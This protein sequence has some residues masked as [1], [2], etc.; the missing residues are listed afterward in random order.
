MPSIVLAEF[1]AVRLASGLLAAMRRAIAIVVG[2]SSS[3][4]TQA[5]TMPRR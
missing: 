3:S 2:I 4:G 5:S 1:L